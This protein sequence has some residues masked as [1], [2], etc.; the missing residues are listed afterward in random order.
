MLHINVN[1]LGDIVAAKLTT[2]NTTDR[3]PVKELSKGLIDRLYADKGYI[4]K[5]QA[6]DL[7]DDGITLVTT[8]KKNMKIKLLPAWDRECYQ[9][10]SSSKRSMTNS[11]TFLRLSILAIGVY[12]VLC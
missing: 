11:K 6:S 3:K 10:A 7:A 1:H 9:G 4:S 12:M 8:K 2:G 5:A